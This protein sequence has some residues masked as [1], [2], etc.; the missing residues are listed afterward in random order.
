M[1][2]TRDKP[3]TVPSSEK[4]GTGTHAAEAYCATV[5]AN[6]EGWRHPTTN[7][8]RDE[9]LR[10]PVNTKSLDNRIRALEAQDGIDS[11]PPCETVSWDG[12]S[13]RAARLHRRI[14]ALEKI[15]NIPPHI[16]CSLDLLVNTLGALGGAVPPAEM[17]A[18]QT[19][20]FAAQSLSYV[21]GQRGYKIIGSFELEFNC[22]LALDLAL[23]NDP[24]AVGPSLAPPVRGGYVQRQKPI[25][26]KDTKACCGCCDCYCHD[27]VIRSRPT[28]RARSRSRSGSPRWIPPRR[29]RVPLR[30]EK[31]GGFWSK[32]AFW[33]R[34][35]NNRNGYDSDDSRSVVTRTESTLSVGF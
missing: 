18:T 22:L 4:S 14:G 6:I 28:R 12:L 1:G 34:D 5:V 21:A 16:A 17:D 32:L 33:R 27:T 20:R 19:L 11:P 2:E 10:M 7:R 23:V 25:N 35:K 9:A 31:S 13:W 24:L 26:V 30:E 3:S 15:R 8:E 29:R